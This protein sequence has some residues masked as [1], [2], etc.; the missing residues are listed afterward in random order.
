VGH[1]PGISILTMLG[2]KFNLFQAC[3][4]VRNLPAFVSA[5]RYIFLTSWLLFQIC[6]APYTIHIAFL[7]FCI[8]EKKYIFKLTFLE[9]LSTTLR[10]VLKIPISM[11]LLKV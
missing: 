1:C 5:C 3:L 2:P 7:Y 9:F 10:A 11:I 4:E 8:V 6:E